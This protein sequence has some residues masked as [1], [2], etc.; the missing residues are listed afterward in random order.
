MV[1]AWIRTECEAV[2][3]QCSLGPTSSSTVFDDNVISED[4]VPA[5]IFVRAV[6]EI[7]E[8]ALA[9]GHQLGSLP[10]CLRV[11]QESR[12]VLLRAVTSECPD[13]VQ[14]G[15]FC[16]PRPTLSEAWLCA[17]DILIRGVGCGGHMGSENFLQEL[18]VE[19]CASCVCLLLYSTLGKTVEQRLH[20][21][22]M[23]M[24]GPQT[25]ALTE[26]LQHYFDLTAG[27]PNMLH[28]TAVC[29]LGKVP[30]YTEGLATLSTD[31]SCLGISIIGAGLFRAAQGGLPPWAVEAIPSVYSSL[32]QALHKDPDMFGLV[33]RLAIHVRLV[34]DRKFGGVE[35]GCLL[36]GRFFEAMNEKAKHSFI[37]QAVEISRSDTHADWKKLKAH[38]KQACGGKKKDT[39]FKQRPGFTKW[40]EMDRV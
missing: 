30:T 36:S 27:N 3:Y 2:L 32:F 18:L 24:D 20:D 29:L 34:H 26:F 33:F 39:D 12:L 17:M 6:S 13:P 22:G 7:M 5:G 37:T 23:S 31:P 4:T 38:I 25:L 10:N 19:S 14:K 35:P 15:S 8:Q 28:T 11:L 9:T 16:D 40:A 1:V 21:A